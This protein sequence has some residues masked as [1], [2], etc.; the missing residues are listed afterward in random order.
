[1]GT[2]Y[3][4][5]ENVDKMFDDLDS[6]GEDFPSPSPELHIPKHM[7]R[8]VTPDFV[9]EHLLKCQMVPDGDHNPV[10]PELDIG[11]ETPFKA[12]G[13]VKTSSP[14]EGNVIQQENKQKGQKENSASPILFDCE[15]ENL[16]LETAEK[17]PEKLQPNNHRKDETHPSCPPVSPVRL[18]TTAAPQGKQTESVQAPT[19]VKHDMTSFLQKLRDAG[20]PKPARAG[21]L[22]PKAMPPAPEPEPEDYFL[23]LEDDAP[24]YISIPNKTAK[25]TKEKKK[26]GSTDTNDGKPSKKTERKREKT[27]EKKDS[28][29][30]K[31][32]NDKSQRKKTRTK[33]RKKEANE[34]NDV[35]EEEQNHCESQPSEVSPASGVSNFEATSTAN[36]ENVNLNPPMLSKSV[37]CTSDEGGEVVRRRKRKPAGQWWM[38]CPQSPPQQVTAEQQTVKKSKHANKDSS[39]PVVSPVKAK[40]GARKKILKASSTSSSDNPRKK[41]PDKKKTKKRNQ[42]KVVP[43]ERYNP[44]IQMRELSSGKKIFPQVYQNSA[45]ENLSSTSDH[46]SPLRPEGPSS[47]KEA[48]KR[49]RT[50]PGNWWQVNPTLEDQEVVS[51]QPQQHKLK[52][53]GEK[54]KRA[55]K[56]TSKPLEGAT[57]P[58]KRSL[59]TRS[60]LCS[61]VTAS[62]PR[63]M[64]IKGPRQSPSQDPIQETTSKV[65]RSGPSSMIGLENYEEDDEDI[66][67]PSTTVQPALSVSEL[68]APPLR[69]LVLQPKD[70]INL[71]DWLKS[72]WP[73]T[74]Q[75]QRDTEITPDDFEWYCYQGRALGLMVDLLSGSICSGKM[76]LGSFMKKPLWVDHSATTVF[77]LLTSSVSL[78]VDC[79]KTCYNAGQSFMVPPGHAYS[80]HN[81]SSQP[82]VFYF[83]R[84]YAEE[85]DQ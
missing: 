20:Q 21:L 84:I 78:I 66:V 81:L 47:T 51:S 50:S 16:D 63:L 48:T 52:A 7:K 62:P 80:I 6:K 70:K 34:A 1:M 13:P 22:Q 71:H 85:L 76:L 28:K 14:I 38:S 53:A 5:L 24:L 3:S 58:K 2:R 67:L 44:K 26:S 72:L 73:S 23:I 32:N 57:K 17:F 46:V 74:D 10:S 37:E 45:N 68:C 35:A 65:I 42:K 82:A 55:K 27:L 77:N 15:E 56:T 79:N 11:S 40:T 31:N 18:E 69:P 64:K 29:S 49:R 61:T 60:D 4:S 75:K 9:P 39:T 83:T 54:G 8:V 41:A 33:E 36:Q 30:V 59:A 25:N 19:R 43:V 12:H